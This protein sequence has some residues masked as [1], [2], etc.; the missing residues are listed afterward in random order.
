MAGSAI[1]Q[2]EVPRT[3]TAN[4]R[5]LDT[6]PV[7][8]TAE[9]QR[10]FNDF[11]DLLKEQN[12]PKARRTGARELLSRGWPQAID[13]LLDVLANE[14]DQ[15]AQMAVIEVIVASDQPNPIFID[16]LIRLLGSNE[17]K[18]RDAAA[19]ALAR[20]N[21]GGVVERLS[22]LAQGK[23][24]P[25]ADLAM[26][27]AAIRALSVLSDRE[28]VMEVPVGLLKDPS[29]E[30]RVRAAQAISDA[31]GIEFGEDIAAIQKWWSIDQ[32]R[33]DLSRSRDRYLV[34]IKQNR[35]LRKRLD[36]VQ[37]I[38]VETLRKLY[39]RMPD[40]QKTDTL[41]EYLQDPMPE[42]R[43]LGVELVSA[44]LTDRKPIPESVHR[45]LLSMI[46]DPSPRVRR[47]VV[48]TLRDLRDA[49]D[50]KLILAQYEE[51][52]DSSVRAAMLNAL[53]RLGDAESIDVMVQALS[54][55]DKQV[56]AEGAL[57]LAV[58][59]E[60]GHL[61]AEEIAPAIRPLIACYRKLAQD[62]PPLQEQLLEAM[63]GIGDP[64]FAPIFA[65]ALAGENEAAVRQAAASG[66]AALGKAEN[67]PLLIEHLSDPDP[68]VRRTVV[69][70]LARI[71]KPEHLEPLFARL[72]AKIESDAIVRSK[73]WEGIRQILRGLP[74]AEQRRWISSRLDPETDKA[75]AERYVELMTAIEKDLATASPQPEDLHEVR[76]KLADG[77]RYAGQ[78]ADAAR[79]YKLVFD[80]YSRSNNP[81]AWDVGLKLLGAKLEANRYD[82]ARA[83]MGQLEQS[84]SD[85]QRDHLCAVLHD[86]VIDELKESAPDRAL[87]ILEHV[88]DRYGPIWTQRFTALR[89][90]AEKLRSEQDVATV[91][92]CLTQMRGDATEVERA[93]QQIRTLGVRAVPPLVEELRG[94]L[95][96]DKTDPIREEQIVEL[97]QLIV[98]TWPGFAEQSDKSAKLQELETLLRLSTPSQGS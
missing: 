30:I 27:N 95:T 53:G 26:R 94:M 5:L 11:V 91:R 41:L 44:M 70:S 77:L 25:V 13:V 39:L 93:R 61:P 90:R 24:Q 71:A 58:L 85:Q 32:R 18:I 73:A 47:E 52:T 3:R 33:T 2:E 59:E 22:R 19:D 7:R 66:I 72:D 23:D 38:L 40:A 96:S 80:T 98:P 60:E 51:E 87:S 9:E 83:L 43:L 4:Q 74:V 6:Q 78:F 56:V 84:A 16:P 69:E 36:V 81:R 48:L 14:K 63:A 55:E 35:Q 75:T 34:K 68:G 82:E 49:T 8:L 1:G 21:T 31:A 76:E 92:R 46:P 17:E 45:R 57:G 79:V 88:G 97:L 50:A 64:Q 62:D 67:A 12:T 89:Q 54:S 29:P 28:E 10:Q 15:V 86:H 42:V 65:E 37:S 20:F